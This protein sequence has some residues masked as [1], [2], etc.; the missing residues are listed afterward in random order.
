MDRQWAAGL[1]PLTF[2]WR[3]RD[4]ARLLADELI[5]ALVAE[6][7]SLPYRKCVLVNKGS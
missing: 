5:A 4:M 6:P 1:T 2:R 7:D 3:M